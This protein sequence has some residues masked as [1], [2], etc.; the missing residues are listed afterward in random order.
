MRAAVRPAHHRLVRR[1]GI[2]PDVER[3][4]EL[5]IARRRRRRSPR[6]SPRTTPRCRLLRPS[7]RRA[8]AAPA[9]RDAARR[10][11]GRRRT[12][13]AR[14]TAAAATASS[15]AGCAIIPYSRALPHAGK[16]CVASMPRSAVVAQR[17]RRLRAAIAGHVVH[18]GEPLRRR[19]VDD[20]RLVPPAMHVAV[21][22][23][24]RVEQRAGFAQ[25]VDDPR[26][27]VPDPQAA[28]ERQ[29]V[30]EAAVA[31]HGVQ[32][33]VV[34]HAVAAARQEV[35]DAVR[36][37]AV[38]DAG[39]LLERHVLAEIDRRRAIVERM[40]ECDPLERRARAPSRRSVPASP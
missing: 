18:A 19:A 2:E 33:V 12:A 32:D 30:G 20:R 5:A 3:V 39:A 28:E 14:P 6:S 9:C 27:R 40:A 29:V 38:D 1:A 34:L 10:S 21:R 8:R 16:N 24:L 23:L 13:A 26:I 17:L 37:R 36:R 22:E 25:L 4:G 7:P 35:V 11:R 31:L 15:P